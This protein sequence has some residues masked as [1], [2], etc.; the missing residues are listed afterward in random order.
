MD[1]RIKA[2]ADRIAGNAPKQIDV[3]TERLEAMDSSMNDMLDQVKSNP[4]LMPHLQTL[5]ALHTN[6]RNTLFAAKARA[7]S[8][9][10]S[11]ALD[12]AHD[13]II[14]HTNALKRRVD[15]VSNLINPTD[16]AA[17]RRIIPHDPALLDEAGLNAVVTKT[18]QLA[19]SP[20][21]FAKVL[22]A[23]SNKALG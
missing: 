21:R 13:A 2:L 16:A 17:L 1:S 12:F 22:S 6:Y 11:R 20:S 15:A 4:L 3:H 9:E 19:N 8:N 23:A 18:N 5:R 10:T 7:L 14:S